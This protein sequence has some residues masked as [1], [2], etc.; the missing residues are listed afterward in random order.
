MFGAWCKT[1]C[2]PTPSLATCKEGASM[3]HTGFF[4]PFLRSMARQRVGKISHHSYSN[5]TLWEPLCDLSPC[6]LR[7]DSIYRNGGASFGPRWKQDQHLGELPDNFLHRWIFVAD[8]PP[9]FFFHSPFKHIS[10]HLSSSPY[11]VYIWAV[12]FQITAWPRK[13]KGVCATPGGVTLQ[14][15]EQRQ[16]GHITKWSNSHDTSPRLCNRPIQN[17]CRKLDFF[18]H[19][20]LCFHLG[21]QLVPISMLSQHLSRPA[22][23]PPRLRS[24]KL[25]VPLVAILTRM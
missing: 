5:Q 4:F 14:D 17:I 19:I 23:P 24:W 9:L 1:D 22:P 6:L 20:S 13:L 16:N 15:R 11:S 25:N 7:L 8:F 2:A 21:G 10:H 3:W 12:W 18:P